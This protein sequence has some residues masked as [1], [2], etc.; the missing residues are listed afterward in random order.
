MDPPYNDFPE[1]ASAK[2]AKRAAVC[3]VLFHEHKK[4]SVRQKQR[5][6]LKI[7]PEGMEIF[8]EDLKGPAL[9]LAKGTELPL[10]VE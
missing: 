6:F 5:L 10:L 1:I 4:V 8:K 2:A 7:L 9:L 3:C